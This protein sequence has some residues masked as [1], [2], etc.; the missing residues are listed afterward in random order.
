MRQAHVLRLLTCCCFIA[1][2]LVVAS[3]QTPSSTR[4]LRTATI[5][6]A[7]SSFTLSNSQTQPLRTRTKSQTLTITRSQTSSLGKNELPPAGPPRVEPPGPTI[8]GPL[9]SIHPCG[10]YYIFQ[11]PFLYFSINC[12]GTLGNGNNPPGLEYNASGTGIFL[13]NADFVTP[14]SPRETFTV[15]GSSATGAFQYINNNA[16]SRGGSVFDRFVQASTRKTIDFTWHGYTKEYTI[17][18]QFISDVKISSLRIT[19]TI[20]AL[21]DLSNVEFARTIDP[22]Q[23]A[24]VGNYAT[25]NWLGYSSGS[26][27]LPTTD[28]CMAAGSIRPWIV[29]ALYTHASQTHNAGVSSGWSDDPDFYLA[30]TNNGN[31]DYVCGLAFKLG[32]MVQGSTQTFQYQYFTG[33]DSATVQNLIHYA[34]GPT[35]T[36]PITTTHTETRSAP[37]TSTVSQSLTAEEPTKTMTGS[38]SQAKSMTN[39]ASITVMR[40]LSASFSP[41]RSATGSSTHQVS[42]TV[43]VTLTY[44]PT[45]SST[46]SPSRTTS[47]TPSRTSSRTP[48]RTHTP[49]ATPSLT[50]TATDT[51]LVTFTHTVDVTN[52]FFITLS[53]ILTLTHTST[54]TET[55]RL[56]MTRQ[57]TKTGSRT[58]TVTRPTRTASQTIGC[59]LQDDIESAVGY[60]KDQPLI[61]YDTNMVNGYE[62]ETTLVSDPTLM[63]ATYHLK[64]YTPLSFTA[65]VALIPSSNFGLPA[66]DEGFAKLQGTSANITI[67]FPEGLVSSVGS[68][69]ILVVIHIPPIAS[70]LID[71]EEH[72]TFAVPLQE[73]LFAMI[74]ELS[75]GNSSS[76]PV[77][78][79][80]IVLFD[81]TIYTQKTLNSVSSIVS[82][83]APIGAA[84]AAPQLQVL[85]VMSMLPCSGSYQ[86]G[87]LAN[88]R[89]LAPA[90]ISAS[91]EG[92]ILGNIFLTCGFCA[93]WALVTFFTSL[94]LKLD[95]LDACTK[96]KFP[97]LPIIVFSLTFPGTAFAVMQLLTTNGTSSNSLALAGGTLLIF[98]LGIPVGGIRIIQN[99]VEMHFDVFEYG[100]WN[101]HSSPLFARFLNVILLPIG[102][103]Q[104]DHMRQMMWMFVT[105]QCRREYLW[106]TLPL[107]SPLVVAA[108]GVIRPSTTLGCVA[109]FG[110]LSFIHL[111]IALIVVWYR[112]LQSTLEDIIFVIQTFLTALVLSFSGSLLLLPGSAA[113]RNGTMVLAFA[114]I[115]VTIVDVLYNIFLHAVVIPRLHDHLPHS[116]AFE[117]PYGPGDEHDQMDEEMAERQRVFDLYGND[118]EE[119]LLLQEHERGGPTAEDDEFLDLLMV[120][121]QPGEGAGVNS[122]T[123]TLQQDNFID[124]LLQGLGERR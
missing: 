53:H 10:P 105:R 98:V 61:L 57:F 83:V 19:T 103:W 114:I 43:S 13:T 94:V 37:V 18:H 45:I 62:Y 69:S 59:V 4:Q 112:P 6:T 81:V 56:T 28:I 39:S 46:Q 106:L 95:M 49:T 118:K 17:S 64:W 77:A 108:L 67:E 92:V 73:M 90:A 26:I 99:Y 119:P 121:Q 76:A 32:T 12:L 96:C 78:P 21:V 107:W 27:T 60:I 47:K 44:N 74:C 34:N 109:L 63:N 9:T 115:V 23:D 117:W 79:H 7:T 42:R 35:G 55:L 41:P 93:L 88:Y 65:L 110:V 1:L 111:V 68:D 84:L 11:T 89:A 31:G 30:G 80:L 51:R 58:T 29:L 123:V 85:V 52:S 20:T 40:S 54:Q 2:E 113:L 33:A 122:A 104:P 38:A 15:K 22:D 24:Q 124:D 102:S 48:S 71:A 14:G 120:Q 72:V 36:S 66:N 87:A 86:Q 50:P 25:T 8:T 91:F 5:S 3:T 82:V 116:F 16:G 101:R 75:E 70:Y 97:A 100:R